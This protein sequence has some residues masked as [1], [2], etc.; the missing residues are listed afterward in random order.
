V[1]TATMYRS[2][3]I[4][5]GASDSPLRPGLRSASPQ[6]AGWPSFDFPES[7]NNTC[8]TVAETRVRKSLDP[9][10]RNT[11]HSKIAKTGV[12]ASW[13][14]ARERSGPSSAIIYV[15]NQALGG[16]NGESQSLESV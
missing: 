11:Q 12:T 16:D 14:F 2:V 5:I 9:A 4:F 3:W 10:R 15:R 6:N 1:I 13:C 8:S 7:S